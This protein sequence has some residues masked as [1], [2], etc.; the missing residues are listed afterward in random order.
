MYTKRASE[1]VLIGGESTYRGIHLFCYNHD[2]LP[3]SLRL[4]TSAIVFKAAIC[5]LIDRKDKQVVGIGVMTPY[6]RRIL[7]FHNTNQPVDWV[8]HE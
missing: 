1:S 8:T 2:I 7:K 4:K 6:V 3:L 5:C